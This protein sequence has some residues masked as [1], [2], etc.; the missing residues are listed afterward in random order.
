MAD[1]FHGFVRGPVRG[2]TS[3]ALPSSDF[4]RT[5]SEG[6]DE[7]EEDFGL[8]ITDLPGLDEMTQPFSATAGPPFPVLILRRE[9]RLGEDVVAGRRYEYPVFLRF[10]Q[11]LR[12]IADGTDAFFPDAALVVG[13]GRAALHA[14]GD[15]LLNRASIARISQRT[16]VHR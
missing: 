5:K 11:P 1:E 14:N 12:S 7:G 8:R 9:P 13:H 2:S 6:W 15:Y 4:D 10:D 3:T 16:D